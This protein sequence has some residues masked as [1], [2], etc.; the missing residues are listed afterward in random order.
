MKADG[1]IIVDGVEV[2]KTYQCCHGGEHFEY[3]KG[4]GATRG[5]CMNCMKMTC[6]RPEC[7]ACVPF[8]KKLEQIEK[9]ARG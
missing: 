2:A 1:Y 6:G 4:S 9:A 8:E 7:H 3:V 5:F